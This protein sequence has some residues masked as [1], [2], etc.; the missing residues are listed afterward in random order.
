MPGVCFSFAR[1]RDT[2][3]C[4]STLQQSPDHHAVRATTKDVARTAAFS[5]SEDDT[6]DRRKPIISEDRS[7]KHPD[8]INSNA[9][10]LGNAEALR[11]LTDSY[12]NGGSSTTKVGVRFIMWCL[13]L[14]GINKLFSTIKI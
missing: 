9:M 3:I 7:V 12:K 4:V 5:T 6:R 1:I 13:C 2:D 10:Q 8:P 14:R 11:Q